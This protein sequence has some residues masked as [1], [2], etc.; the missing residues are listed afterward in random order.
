MG[1]VR[2]NTIQR[3]VRTA[4]LSVLM[5]CTTSVHN[6]NRAGLDQ[7]LTATR[8]LTILYDHS[9]SKTTKVTGI[10]YCQQQ[11]EKVLPIPILILHTRSVTD[12]CVSTL[13]ASPIFWLE[14]Q[15]VK[16]LRT[17]DTWDRQQD[18]QTVRR[19][20]R[21]VSRTL[22]HWCRTVLTSSKHF[23]YNRPYRRK[24]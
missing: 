2:Q 13:I 21:S 6:T 3:T 4:H 1:P 16:T 15:G 7:L 24:V 23:C 22:R 5:M 20:C 8:S 10:K 9:R 11:V 17:Q 18:V 14:Y 19:Q 12:T